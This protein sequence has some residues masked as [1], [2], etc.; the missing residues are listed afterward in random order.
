MCDE[1]I[2]H[3]Y[4]RINLLAYTHH[5][6]LFDGTINLLILIYFLLRMIFDTA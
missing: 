6:V 3:F 2:Q 4:S 1:S 5:P